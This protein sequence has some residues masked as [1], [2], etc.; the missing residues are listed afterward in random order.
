[1]ITNYLEILE[2]SLKQKSA[3]L[4]EIAD[5]C[6]QQEQLLKQE[7][8]PLEEFDVYVERKGELITKLT[9]LDEGFETLYARVREQLETNKDVYRE[10]IAR[11][12]QLVTKVTEQSV[13]IQAQEARNKQMVEAHFA[14]ER[15]GLRA[16][17]QASKVAYGYY[18]NMNN[19]NVV[20]PQILD[21][22]K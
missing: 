3:I 2:N 13:S 16:G 9:K 6:E 14:K 17:R 20:L 12:Q 5:N 22:K 18:K 19:T 10:Q 21:Q 15:A 11:L 8:L 4:N 1:M 7:K